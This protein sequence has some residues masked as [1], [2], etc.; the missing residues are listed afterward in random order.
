MFAH[1]NALTMLASQVRGG[2]RAAAASLCLELE[3]RMTRVV[4]QVLRTGSDRSPLDRQ[5]QREL[6]RPGVPHDPP[7]LVAEVARRICAQVVARLQHGRGAPGI[8]KDT[9]RDF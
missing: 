5:I 8:L 9:V 7:R 4:Q 3:P 2:D 6:G 1:E